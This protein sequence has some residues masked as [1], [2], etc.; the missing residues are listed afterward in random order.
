MSENDGGDK[1][2]STNSLLLSYQKKRN[3]MY[4]FKNVNN[5]KRI[6]KAKEAIM[7]LIIKK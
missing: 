5:Q 7:M 1:K 2:K 4:I 3:K 6:I